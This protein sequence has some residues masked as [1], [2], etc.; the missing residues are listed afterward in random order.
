MLGSIRR[1]II[2]PGLIQAMYCGAHSGGVLLVLGSF[3]R[4]II[5]PVLIQAEC[6][7]CRAHSGVRFKL[8]QTVSHARCAHSGRHS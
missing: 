8:V 1:G 4:K 3:R 6:Y 2:S 5:S 7:G